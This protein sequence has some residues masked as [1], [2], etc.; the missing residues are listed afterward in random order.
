[1]FSTSVLARDL[2]FYWKV[3]SASCDNS[4]HIIGVY[5]LYLCQ[6]KKE[7]VRLSKHRHQYTIDV[8]GNLPYSFENYC[9]RLTCSEEQSDG[10]NILTQKSLI[11]QQQRVTFISVIT[12]S[13]CH[14]NKAG[15]PWK[16]I[17][18]EMQL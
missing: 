1:M 6:W 5:L 15:E 3:D 12:T 10:W 13:M 9:R 11:L 7:A 16:E 8:T 14:Y 17:L 2:L 18:V 4:A